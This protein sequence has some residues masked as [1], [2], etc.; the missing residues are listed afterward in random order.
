MTGA[1]RVNLKRL[2]LY[3]DLPQLWDVFQTV[4]SLS[5]LDAH[6][7][8]TLDMMHAYLSHTD[9]LIN[10][11]QTIFWDAMSYFLYRKNHKIHLDRE[12]KRTREKRKGR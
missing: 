7:F 10:V 4:C 2:I 6:G 11:T 3:T 5:S 9:I 12:R 8:I 1:Q